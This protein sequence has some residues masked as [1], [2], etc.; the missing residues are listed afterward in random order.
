MTQNKEVRALPELPEVE[1]IR[2]TLEALVKGKTIQDVIVDYPKLVKEPD[3][4]EE[5]KEH[6]RGE[7]VEHIGRRGKFLL[8]YFTHYVLVS[9]LRM[10]GKYRL[11]KTGEPI[12]KHTHVRFL[13]TDG[14]ELRY[15]DVRKFGTM[16]LFKKG[17]EEASLPLSDLG[18]E[19]FPEHLTT[20]YLAEQLQK[21]NRKVKVVLLDQRVVVGL[22]NI[23]VDEVLFRSSI[24]P[25]RSAA[26]LGE[27]EIQ[28]LYEEIV[29]TLT[30]AVEKGGSTIRTYINSQGQIGSFQESLYVYGR[31]GE[32][33]V[34][35]GSLIEKIVVGGRGTHFC[36][37]CQ[38]LIHE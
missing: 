31:K 27:E 16:H 1:T 5:F 12:D 24:H 26:S 30:E 36:P 23:Y 9:H 29:A 19:P 33:C 35:C 18:P 15:N 13:F 28:K 8:I 34:R 37:V 38:N 32:S 2:R 14:T 7:T 11:N 3:D 25:E 17:E 22:G 10:E 21:T 20:A 6:L 4:V